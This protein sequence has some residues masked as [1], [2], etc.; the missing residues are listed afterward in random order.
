MS[1]ERGSVSV[2]VVGH[3]DHGKSTLVGR[4]LADTNNLP[5]GKL[6]AIRRNCEL[7]AKPMEYAYLLDA[8][9]DEQAQG[10]TIDSARC[11]FRNGGRDYIII[12]APG[13]IEFLK[14]MVSGA[15]RADAALLVIDAHEGVREN[16]RRH[17]YFLSMLG[18]D[19][20]AVVINKMDLVGYRKE[21]FDAIVAEY[22]AFLEP[23]HM[24][25][26]AFVPVDSRNGVCVAAHA[27]ELPWYRGATVLEMFGR[28][29]R[30]GDG[31]SG[32]FRMPVQDVYKFTAR[33]DERRIVAGRVESGSLRAGDTVVFSPSN[34]RAV[35]KSIEIF[36]R[37]DAT[38]AGPSQCVGFTLNEQIYVT[39]GELASREDEP[40][41]KVTARLRV[42]LFWLATSPMIPD[43]AY[44]FKLGTA[45][46]PAQI[47]KVVRVLDASDLSV[48]E[49]RQEVRRHEVAECILR[50][51]KPAAFDPCNDVP[52]TGRFV[53]VDEYRIAGGG[54]VREA[55]P[56]DES[57]LRAEA[58]LRDRKWVRSDLTP[59]LRADRYG[60]QAALIVITGRRGVGRKEL[61]RA[62]ERKLFEGGRMVYY[63]GMGSIVHGLDVD[64]S[65]RDLQPDEASR[66]HIRRLGEVLHVLLDAGLIVV[67]TAL[68][69]SG[70]NLADIET[71][72][73]PAQMVSIRVGPAS[74]GAAD[75]SFDAPC[76]A[77]MAV[78]DI[79]Q[80][81]VETAVLPRGA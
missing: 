19:Q 8:L 72:I 17:G 65:S 32:P 81:L 22:S 74:E 25:P 56:D 43:K 59:E 27:P 78:E 44:T 6:E 70:Q 77:P 29:R 61:A 3:V 7:N 79:L 14:N 20:F 28:F 30:G 55:L 16:S 63:L 38:S 66:E 49:D 4:L 24:K 54:I 36:N 35:V 21:V 37:P 40:A 23:I 45:E 31:A 13:H 39:R 51:R 50:T 41:P 18:I 2:V 47:E 64:I 58:V 11:F 76:D 5:E 12:D 68:E 42:D 9:K 46:V 60:Q 26:A 57:A 62:L 75:L 73:R 34:K 53:I 15:A 71:L 52:K 67:S 33:D 69:L 1:E 48:A 10:I 80:R